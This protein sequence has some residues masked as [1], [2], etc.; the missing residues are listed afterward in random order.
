MLKKI[1]VRNDSNNDIR[2]RPGERL[3]HLFES[4]C[5]QF[6][7]SGDTQH[8]AVDSMEGSWSYK[9]LDKRANQLA[10]Y[11][12]DQRLGAGD[13]IG[14]LF[15]KSVHSYISMLAVLKIHAAYVPL[16]P[17]FPV[18]RI[19]FIARDAGLNSIL[20]MSQYLPLTEDSGLSVLCV[21]TASA[22]INS[23]ANSRLYESDTGRPVSELCYII[24][25]SGSTGR[26]KGVPIEHAGICN[27][28]RVAAEVV[29]IQE[30]GPGL[31]RPY[32]RL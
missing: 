2:W 21:D 19:A 3:H 12:K 25:T 32:N 18:D 31:S 1:L 20:T 5:D 29:W 7:E 30:Y 26:P 13:I 6:S 4:R 17:A 9:E 11:M 8:L 10:R 28:V 14:L 23:Q 22:R 27:F 24:Y 16:D 15:D